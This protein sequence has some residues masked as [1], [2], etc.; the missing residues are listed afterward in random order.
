MKKKTITEIKAWVYEGL[1]GDAGALKYFKNH[2]SAFY[3]DYFKTPIQPLVQNTNVNAVH[4]GSDVNDA[5]RRLETAFLR[6]INARKTSIGDPAVYVD[7][8]RIDS[9]SDT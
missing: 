1:G 6:V 5:K 2:P 9:I 7:G 4:I 3:P 8:N